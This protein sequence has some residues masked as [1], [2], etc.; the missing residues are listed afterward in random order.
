VESLPELDRVT[1]RGVLDPIQRLPKS[2]FAGDIA[3]LREEVTVKVHETTI[4]FGS[5][6]EL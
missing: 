2:M 5:V 1:V 6:G 3:S 4:G